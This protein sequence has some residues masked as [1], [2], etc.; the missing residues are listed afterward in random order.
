MCQI[1][2]KNSNEYYVRIHTYK[3]LIFQPSWLRRVVQCCTLLCHTRFLGVE[4]VGF[5]CFSVV[6]V[7]TWWASNKQHSTTQ[8]NQLGCNNKGLY[9]W[10]TIYT[11]TLHLFAILLTALGFMF[12]YSRHKCKI[13]DRNWS[14]HA[15]SNAF[16]HTT[17]LEVKLISYRII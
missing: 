6:T 7:E 16:C 11:H 13:S 4:K 14:S 8:R 1:S 15:D 5:C 12:I 9:I 17:E 2:H 10:I 3:P